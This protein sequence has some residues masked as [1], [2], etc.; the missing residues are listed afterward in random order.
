[1]SERAHA[2]VDV[3]LAEARTYRALLDDVERSCQRPRAQQQRELPSLSGQQARDL[4]V[5]A[6]YAADGRDADDLLLGAL[7]AGTHTV[8]RLVF[9]DSLLLDEHDRHRPAE[10]LARRLQHLGGATRVELDVDSGL[11]LL[12]SGAGV[13]QL[14]TGDDDVAL[15]QDRLV[16]AGVIELRAERRALGTLGL[17]RVILVVD[18]PE[19][20]RRGGAE[21][22]QRLVRILH[23]GQLHDDPVDALPRDDRLRHAE[24]VHAIAQRRDVLLDREVL[25]LLDA[26]R[27]ERDAH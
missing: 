21:H 19:L 23:A 17:G 24:F 3:V 16:L 26:V 25:A 6:E 27:R 8:A 4:E 5:A 2:A 12:E 20:E 9:L 22:A 10:V 15:E 18:Q 1:M 13:H 14:L 11:A 7:G